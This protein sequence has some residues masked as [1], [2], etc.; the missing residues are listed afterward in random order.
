MTKLTRVTAKIFGETADATLTDPEI[1]QFGSAKAGT[2]N[3]TGDV[4]TIQGLTAWSN[5]WI[6]AV[7]PT[8]QFPS[9]PERTGVDKVLSYQNAYVL[10][11][12]IPEWDS[13][14]DYYTNGFCS[15]AGKIY[16]SLA[17]N[18]IN[19]DP[20]TETTY[21]QEFTSGGARNI[22][23]IVQST[24]PLTDAGLHLLDGALLSGSGSYGAFVDY[25]ADLYDSGDYTDIFETEANWQ[26]SVTTYGVC[27]KFVYDSVNNTVRLPKYSNKIYSSSISSIA[28]VKGNGKTLGITDGTNE[29]GLTA[30]AISGYG[31]LSAYTGASTTN[32]GTSNSAINLT[33]NKTYG[34]STDKTKSGVIADLADITTSLDGYYYI[35]I[36]NSTKTQIQVD[37]DEIATDLNGKADVDLTNVNNSGTSRGA[38]WTMPS[39]TYINLTLGASGTTYTAP[40][41]GWIV[42]YNENSSA[43]GVVLL[44][45]NS[46]LRITTSPYAGFSDGSAFI[47]CKKNDVVQLLYTGTFG[48]TNGWLRFVYAVG[49]ERE[50][51]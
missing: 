41:N 45:T 10:Q 27:G 23:E 9:L 15:K 44:N 1:G 40:A 14:T 39:N 12:G 22:G 20:E 24:I 17:D 3:G 37:I 25:I 18:N 33:Y 7:T 51:S 11:Q 6:D 43:G 32:V 8:Q 19:K 50:A 49:S 48:S 4:A 38:G 21:W 36:A 34:I 42:A 5:G 13:A 2:Y 46:Y 16:I 31:Y 30:S 47:P 28:P 26:S 35:V 29:F